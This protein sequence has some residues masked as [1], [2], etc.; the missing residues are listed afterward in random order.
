MKRKSAK[1]YWFFFLPSLLGVSL[2][3]VVPFLY[4][5]YYAV[6]DNLGRKNLWACRTSPTP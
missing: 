6:I 3:Y 1:V 5:F 4:S 2:F